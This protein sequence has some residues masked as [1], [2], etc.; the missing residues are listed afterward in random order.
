MATVKE[1]FETRD[2]ASGLGLLA[3]H[4]KNKILI[5]NLSRKENPAKLEYEL[6]KVAKRQGI[7]LVGVV[8]KEPVKTIVPSKI[9]GTS[10][11]F[12]ANMDKIKVVRNNRAVEYDDLPPEI[13][14]L[15]NL[16]RDGYKEIRSLHEKLKL[17]EKA[18]GEDR[19][20]LLA[21]LDKLDET[22]RKNW[23]TIDAWQP[24]Q[25][26]KK[27]VEPTVISHKRINANRKY[28]S[29]NVKKLAAETN[30]VK[31]DKLRNKIQL[32]VTELQN[33]QEKL[34]HATIEEL[35]KLGIKA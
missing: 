24:G 6:R 3:K 2:Y 4:S 31:A 27:V 29:S 34:K 23:D 22:I 20:P 28:I 30:P 15:W 32:R 14:L 25:E 16:N 26:V 19:V 8:K 5:Q 11:G 21:R 35:N 10:R 13:Q 9:K 12:G 17:L 18:P 1:W 33:A 7:K